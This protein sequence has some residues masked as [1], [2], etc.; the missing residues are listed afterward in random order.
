MGRGAGVHPA[1][2]RAA[3]RGVA[4]R[5]YRR[6]GHRLPLCARGPVRACRVRRHGV[7]AAAR[8]CDHRFTFA[9]RGRVRSP[10]TSARSGLEA[11]RPVG[12]PTGSASRAETRESTRCCLRR[13]SVG[14]NRSA[15]AMDGGKATAA[16][17][18]RRAG[19]GRCRHGECRTASR[20]AP[21]CNSPRCE[22]PRGPRGRWKASPGEKDG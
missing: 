17:L 12:S 10:A 3:S 13:R 7:R 1:H 2:P 15:A 4:G 20:D 14:A 22:R 18:V 16:C 11:D 8:A 6:R 5:G 9:G 21:P 19:F